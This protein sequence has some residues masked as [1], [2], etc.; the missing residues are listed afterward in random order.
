MKA[1]FLE[2]YYAR[3]RRPMRDYVVRLMEPALLTARRFARPSNAVLDSWP[4]K[5]VLTALGLVDLPG[6]C[7][8][9]L[10]SRLREEGIALLDL[11]RPPTESGSVIIVPDSFLASFDIGPLIATARMLSLLGFKPVVAPVL[12]NGKALEVRGF[13]R[14]HAKS[15][16]HLQRTLRLYAAL[17]WPLVAVEPA[18]TIDAR[19]HGADFL[20]PIDVFLER[21]LAGDGNFERIRDG[22][23]LF[24]H[25]TEAT[26]DPK[27]GGRWQKIFAHFGIEVAVVSV[28]I[29]ELSG[30]DPIARGGAMATGFSCRCQTKRF[31]QGRV[32]HPLEVL[33]CHVAGQ[34]SGYGGRQN[35]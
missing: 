25:C 22:G 6:F 4:A 32:P 20:L 29:F 9:T 30:A 15:N 21:Q 2:T 17:G 27:A 12:A 28:A 33:A 1:S 31:G 34:G 10:E 8:R 11:S 19:R 16:R 14:A 18:T 5:R 13:G 23:S 26:S 24:L 35:G 7:D 3:H